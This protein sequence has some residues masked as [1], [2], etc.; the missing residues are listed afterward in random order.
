[1]DT[2]EKKKGTKYADI[3]LHSAVT[4]THYV[5]N[6][7]AVLVKK[8]HLLMKKSVAIFTVTYHESVTCP[9]MYEV[10]K[11]IQIKYMPFTGRKRVYREKCR[12]KSIF[13]LLLVHLSNIKN[14]Y[15]GD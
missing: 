6:S 14:W 10:S 12:G 7:L 11:S 2:C 13:N 8:N 4:Y 3:A 9:L 15:F 1:M 5:G